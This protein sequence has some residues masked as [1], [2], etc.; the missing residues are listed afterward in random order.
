MDRDGR[1]MMQ[2]RCGLMLR[3]RRERKAARSAH[4]VRGE[5]VHY[6]G[7]GRVH[8]SAFMAEPLRFRP[9]VVPEV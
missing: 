5:A 3:P 4:D 8:I 1:P 2:S 6:D 7:S 9:P